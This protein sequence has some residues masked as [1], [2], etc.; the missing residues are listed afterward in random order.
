MEP[1]GSRTGGNELAPRSDFVQ[2]LVRIW[3]QGGGRYTS[4]APPA[5]F[6]AGPVPSRATTLLIWISGVISVNAGMSA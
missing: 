2:T 5:H 6:G 1:S 3:I 4:Q